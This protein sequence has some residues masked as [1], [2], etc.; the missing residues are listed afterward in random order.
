MRNLVA[1]ALGLAALSLM[2]GAA[3]A[4]KCPYGYE[5][6]GPYCVPLAR[7]YREQ[8]YGFDATPGP[9]VYGGQYDS[10][11]DSRVNGRI[12][13]GGCPPGY[14]SASGGCLRLRR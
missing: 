6:N 4:R 8:F 13:S 10:R 11:V 5:R 14:Y 12:G 2:S 7:Q 9:R 1:L 3:S